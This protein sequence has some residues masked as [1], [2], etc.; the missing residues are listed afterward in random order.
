MPG[1]ILRILYVLNQSVAMLSIHSF[2]LTKTRYYRYHLLT[3]EETEAHR[4]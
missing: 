4:E 3:G 2:K 1:T